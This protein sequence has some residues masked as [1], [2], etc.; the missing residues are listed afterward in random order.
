MEW[1]R[2]YF[3]LGAYPGHPSAK[4]R[5]R[6]ARELFSAAR[7]TRPVHQAELVIAHYSS[8]PS[9]WGKP[10]VRVVP[11]SVIAQERLTTVTERKK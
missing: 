6:F 4:A 2:V 10:P 3:L 9:E 8:A 1:R 5:E 7:P 11:L